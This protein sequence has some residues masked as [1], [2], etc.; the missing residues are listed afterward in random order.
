MHQLTLGGVLV[1]VQFKRIKNVHLSVYPPTGR[2][3]IA[4]PERMKLDAI[5]LFAISKLGWIKKQ[6]KKIQGQ[7]HETPREYLERESHYVWGK[8][9]LLQV[10][11]ADQAPSIEMTH[12]RIVLR[13]RPGTGEARRSALIEAWY[14]DQ[15]KKAVPS[16][17]S[18]WEPVIG[19]KTARFFVQK[20][21]TKWGSCNIASRIIRLNTDLA[22][23]PRNCLEYIIVHELAHMLEP[24]HN[25]RFA[26][27]MDHLVPD[28]KFQRQ[29]QNRLPVRAEHWTCG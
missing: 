2:V 23:T 11:E 7:E 24:T 18:K 16:L 9:Y 15:M 10:V 12:R 4:A 6:Q 3:R 1:D 22:K 25:A 26:S 21:R 17:I 5:R 27:L 28:W 19:V 29:T 20:M 8:R 14:R 13:I